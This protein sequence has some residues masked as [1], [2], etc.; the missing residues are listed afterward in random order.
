MAGG[1]ETH[2]VITPWQ[3]RSRLRKGNKKCP[4]EGTTGG[5]RLS[6]PV[7]GYG[8][9]PG[10]PVPGPVCAAGWRHGPDAPD[11]EK[12]RL[13][14][15]CA[16]AMPRQRTDHSRRTYVFPDDLP[17]RLMRFKE[18]SG[19][20]WGELARRLGT[21][22]PQPETLEGRGAA[23]SAASDGPPGVGPRPVPGPRT[24]G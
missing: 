18:E 22:G 6:P 23:H 9:A 5:G 3:R 11:G 12:L 14:T 21:F 19:L 4:Q 10:A 8:H 13:G 7:P 20:S 15:A 2:M 17:E 16:C 24:A 1:E